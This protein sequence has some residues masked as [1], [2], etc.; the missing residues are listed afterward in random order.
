MLVNTIDFETG[1]WERMYF[2]LT[3]G[4]ILFSTSD[5]FYPRLKVKIE[6]ADLILAIRIK[7]SNKLMES[8]E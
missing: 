3:F 4:F 5:D 1:F 2:Y 8:D 7:E 6:S